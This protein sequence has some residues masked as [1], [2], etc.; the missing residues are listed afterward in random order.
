MPG[1]GEEE[2]RRGRKGCERMENENGLL[3]V[4]VDVLGWGLEGGKLGVG[5]SA[6]TIA[7][8]FQGNTSWVP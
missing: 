7:P 8:L 2:R 6:V 5:E 4:D 1:R 3:G